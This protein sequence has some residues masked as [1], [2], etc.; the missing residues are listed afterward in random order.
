[1]ADGVG[2]TVAFLATYVE[3]LVRLQKPTLEAVLKS[4]RAKQVKEWKAA[5]NFWERKRQTLTVE[6]QNLFEDWEF[7]LC[8]M[9]TLETVA[10]LPRLQR[11]FQRVE[12][13]F[14]EQKGALQKVGARNLQLALRSRHMSQFPTATFV[15]MFLER[16]LE[17]FAPEQSEVISV[18]EAQLCQISAEAQ[19][20]ARRSCALAF[21][22]LQDFFAKFA[23]DILEL[24]K[25]N[26]RDVVMSK[27]SQKYAEWMQAKNFFVRHFE[28]LTVEEKELLED[29]ELVLC[30]MSTLETVAFLPRLQRCFQRVE[31]F[32][33]EQKG[34]LQKVGARNLQLALRSLHML[35]FPTSTFVRVFL[36]RYSESFT[37]EQSEIIA[38]WEAQFCQISAEAQERAR[39]SC[40]QAFLR[41]QEFFAKFAKDILELQ[42]ENLRDVVMSNPAHRHPEWMRAQK[43]FLRQHP[44]LTVEE[45][46]LLDDWELVLCEMSTLETV[47]F[48]PRLQRC[49]QRV[50]SFFTEQKGALQKVGA[51]NLQLALRS[52]HMLQFPTSTFVRVFLER[53][54]ESFTPEQ[55]E[56][57]AMWE[58]QFCQI[59]A[60]AQERARR[61]CAQAFLR[62]QEFFAKFAKDILELQKENLRDVVMSNQ[63][64]SHAEWWHAQNFFR[65]Q[66]PLL[67]VEEKDLLE[68]WELVLCEMSTLETVAFLPRLQRCFQRV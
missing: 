57:I 15:R 4:N 53:Y 35:Q 68:D 65:R 62:L 23:K 61:S 22:R 33:T 40:A 9:S 14:T 6:Q 29:W 12:S 56:I 25:E 58:A 18:W 59:S 21:A 39:R 10:F 46:D 41:L 26:F 8:N 28:L 52:L 20:Q 49:F 43:F 55:S 47:A 13:F 19:E 27:Q 51:R 7:V 66:H 32:F 17:S 24:Q 50:E 54:S 38:M 11:C 36:E 31:S 30:E 34:A 16:Y 48:L 1:M 2:K 42:K 37:P 67:T 44:L 3:E 64:H 5:Q 63:A 60:E 45:R